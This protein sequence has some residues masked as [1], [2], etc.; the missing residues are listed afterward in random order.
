MTAHFPDR[1]ESLSY[2]GLRSEFVHSFPHSLTAHFPDRLESLSYGDLPSAV[3]GLNSFIRS[4]F[5][6][7]PLPRQAG[8]PVLPRS[9]ARRLRSEFVHSFPHSLTAHFPD[10]LESL[11]YRGPPSAV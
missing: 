6:D 3:R 8:K 11:S 7:G 10:R 9:A 2:R 5:V 1:L 4:P